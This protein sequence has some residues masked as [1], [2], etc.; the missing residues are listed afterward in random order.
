MSRASST[1]SL[2]SPEGEARSTPRWSGGC[3]ADV[4]ATGTFLG[5]VFHTLPFL[6]PRYQTAIAIVAIELLLLGWLRHRF[7]DTGF[8]RSCPSRSAVR[9]LPA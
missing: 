6:I 8:V 5:G 3:S 2:G 9:S 4:S 7:F 1:R